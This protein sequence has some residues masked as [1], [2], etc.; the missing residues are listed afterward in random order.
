MTRWRS[1]Q[2][3]IH[4]LLLTICISILLLLTIYV[5]RMCDQVALYAGA[6]SQ[7]KSFCAINSHLGALYSGWEHK[8]NTKSNPFALSTDTWGPSTQAGNTDIILN[9][10][11][12]MAH[13][14]RICVCLIYIYIY[15]YKC[16]YGYIYAFIHIGIYVCMYVGMYVCM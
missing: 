12:G 1:A 2:A 3:Q 11:R 7:Q 9:T 15:I 5:C 4:I 10:T 6:N 16:I 14:Y 13:G 8:T